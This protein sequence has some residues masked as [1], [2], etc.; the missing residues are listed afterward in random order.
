MAKLCMH[1]CKHGTNMQV[2]FEHACCMPYWREYIEALQVSACVACRDIMLEVIGNLHGNIQQ[3]HLFVVYYLAST[4]LNHRM[5][6][7]Y[8]S[9]VY[10]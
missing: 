4:A 8:M 10:G 1:A 6:E 9:R 3:V 2:E 7:A 5:Y